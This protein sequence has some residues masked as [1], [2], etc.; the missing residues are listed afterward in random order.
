MLLWHTLQVT[1]R[2]VVLQHM[3][4]LVRSADVSELLCVTLTQ[5]QAIKGNRAGSDAERATT[6]PLPPTHRDA[7]DAKDQPRLHL[8]SLPLL[9]IIN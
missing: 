1:Q 2:P 4:L 3:P 5:C 9:T 6:R 7:T 8:A